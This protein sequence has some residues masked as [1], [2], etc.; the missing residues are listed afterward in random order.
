[1]AGL[2]IFGAL[3]AFIAWVGFNK[4]LSSA[5]AWTVIAAAVAVVLVLARA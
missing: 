3:L 2:A 4:R 5:Q 1:M